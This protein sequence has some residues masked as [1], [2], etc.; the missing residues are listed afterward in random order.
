[1]AAAVE[2]FGGLDAVINNAGAISLTDVEH[3]EPKRF[4]LMQSVNARAVF[5]CARA[6][7]PWLRQYA[8]YT[9]SKFGMTML[10]LGMT[11]E[12]RA[13]GVAVNCLWPRRLMATSAIEFAVPDGAA[14]FARSRICFC[15]V[16]R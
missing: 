4:G 8:P 14:L 5:V 13:A 1:M 2:R 10:S 7:L 16:C 3:T 15:E 12:F 9:L 6:T 11:E